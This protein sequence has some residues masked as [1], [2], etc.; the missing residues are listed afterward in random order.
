MSFL[1]SSP[2]P[3]YFGVAPYEVII[4]FEVLETDEE[5]VMMKK[6]FWATD[7]DAALHAARTEMAEFTKYDYMNTNCKIIKVRQIQDPDFD[8]M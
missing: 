8:K 5:P 3:Y 7:A 2:H 1:D 6:V 4:R